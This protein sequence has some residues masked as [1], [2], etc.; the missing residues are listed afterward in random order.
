MTFSDDEL[1]DILDEVTTTLGQILLRHRELAEGIL[2]VQQTDRSRDKIESLKTRLAVEKEKLAQ[3]RQQQQRKRE[4]ERNRKSHETETQTEAK[5]SSKMVSVRDQR[6][7]VI[8]WVQ[9][10]GRNN[11]NFLDRRSR[12]VG[13]FINGQTY[14]GRGR[15]VGNGDQ[16]LRVL[17]Q[18]LKKVG[19]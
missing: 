6:G 15:V 11:F 9:S 3:V 5:S 4:L 16:G 1:L 17:G 7:Q 19:S 8:G 18:T 12:L 13:R 2:D 14:D 10:V